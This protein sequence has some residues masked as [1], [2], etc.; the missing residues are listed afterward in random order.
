MKELSLNILD[1]VQNSIRAKADLVSIE[2][3][4]SHK[5]DLYRITIIDN[6]NGI[7]NEILK[8]VTDP[9]ITTRTKRKMGLGLP[10]LKYHA[11]ITGG[12]LEIISAEKKGTTVTAILSNSHLDRQPL[13]DIS[14]VIILMIAANPGINFSYSHK[15]DNGK[16]SFTTVETKEY[17]GTDTLNDRDLLKDIASMI[18]E[19]LKNIDASGILTR[20]KPV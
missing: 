9:F 13:G 8:N 7:S 19:N 6:G 4:E 5:T 15:T 2:I 12:G 11:E 16:F 1:I 18:D 17:L 3:I 20:E 10:L 14:G